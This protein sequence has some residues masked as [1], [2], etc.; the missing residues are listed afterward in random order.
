MDFEA[1][2]A[3]LFDY[4]KEQDEPS[5]FLIGEREHLNRIRS[6]RN[7]AVV[8]I[9]AAVNALIDTRENTRAKK[10]YLEAKSFGLPINKYI[11]SRV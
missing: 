11:E 10:L 3:E 7:C 6:K 2:C 8:G 5:E 1:L 9:T 4:L